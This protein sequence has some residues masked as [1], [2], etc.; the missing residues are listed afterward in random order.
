MLRAVCACRLGAP[1]ELVSRHVDWRGFESLCAALLASIGYTVRRNVRFRRPRAEVDVLATG[2]SVT[3]LVDCKHWRRDPG[4]SSYAKMAE[5]QRKR[6]ERVRSTLDTVSPI[7]IVIVT[8]GESQTRFVDGAAVVP[9]H[10]LADFSEN[11]LAYSEQMTF[12]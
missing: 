9:I 12:S 11:V 2:R 4:V 10:T 1:V 8:L 5:A 6:A 7:G 3:L